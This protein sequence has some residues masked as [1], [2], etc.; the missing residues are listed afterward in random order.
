MSCCM[1]RDMVAIWTA[2]TI[3]V[4][5]FCFQKSNKNKRNY[6]ITVCWYM[7]KQSGEVYR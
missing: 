5:K 7:K 4:G 1:L 2:S 6:D 3:A